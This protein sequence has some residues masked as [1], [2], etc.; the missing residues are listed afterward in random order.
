MLLNPG[1]K[2]NIEILWLRS[3]PSASF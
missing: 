3:L 1:N 2:I